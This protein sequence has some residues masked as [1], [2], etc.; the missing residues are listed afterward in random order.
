MHCLVDL[1]L[2]GLGEGGEGGRGFFRTQRTSLATALAVP[3]IVFAFSG[4]ACPRMSAKYFQA[5]N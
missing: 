5:P 4:L 2:S 3:S 1:S